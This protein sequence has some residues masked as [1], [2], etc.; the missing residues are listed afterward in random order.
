MMI[1]PPIKIGEIGDGKND[2]VLPTFG[3]YKSL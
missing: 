3:R 1:I 2:I